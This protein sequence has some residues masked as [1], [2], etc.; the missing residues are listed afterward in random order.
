MV[1]KRGEDAGLDQHAVHQAV[2]GEE[3]AHELARHDER[4]EKR[5]AIEP[6]QDGDGGRI[7]AEHEIAA[8]RH[9]EDGDQGGREADDHEGEEMSRR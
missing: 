8:D 5:P 3:G 1:C 6:A 9:R 4:D 7:V 2:L